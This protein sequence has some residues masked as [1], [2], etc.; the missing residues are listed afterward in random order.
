MFEIYRDDTVPGLPGSK[1]TL[2]WRLRLAAG[3]RIIAT[4]TDGFNK[5]SA[6]LADIERV[7]SLAPTAKSVEVL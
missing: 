4:S 7:K 5:R 1:P 6:A 3:G 2:R